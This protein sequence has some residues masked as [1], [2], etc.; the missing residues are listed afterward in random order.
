MDPAPD[1]PNAALPDLRST[2]ALLGWSVV[3]AQG[4]LLG[5]VQQLLLDLPTGRIAYAMVACGGFMGQGE[6]RFALDWGGLEA[7]DAPQRFIWHGAAPQPQA[8]G[9]GAGKHAVS[10]AC[11]CRTPRAR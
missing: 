4:G 2:E 3:D 8:P 9:A 1:R 10:P 11:R 5:T 6:A 7:A